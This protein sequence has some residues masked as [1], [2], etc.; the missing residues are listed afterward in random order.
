MDPAGPDDGALGHAAEP[1]ATPKARFKVPAERLDALKDQIADINRKVARLQK[2]GYSE[3]EPVAI[4]VGEL[5]VEQVKAPT[6]ATL[7]GFRVVD[8]VFADVVLVSPKPPKID[9]WEFVAALSHV[10]DV[11]AVLRVCPGADVAEGELKRFREA[12]ACCDHC[13]TDRKRNET[14]VVRNPAAELKQVGRQ[15]LQAYTGLKNPEVLCQRAELLFAAAAALGSAE[16]EWAPEGRSRS[17]SSVRAYLPFVACS[18]RETGWLSRTEARARADGAVSTAD[19][20]LSRGLFAKPATIDPLKPQECD[21]SRASATIAFCDEYF[22]GREVDALSDYENSLRV[23]MASGVLHPKLVGIVASAV[24]FYDRDLERRARADSWAKVVA[25]STWQGAVGERQVFEDLK[26]V[27]HRSWEGDFG[28]TNL[29]TLVSEEGHCFTYFASRDM[30]LSVGQSVSLKATV[31]K[32]DTYAPKNG[33]TPHK[34]TVL[35][36]CAL[37]ARARVVGVDTVEV[38]GD[39]VVSNPEAVARGEWAEYTQ[40]TSTGNAYHLEASDGRRFVFH[41]KAKKKALTVGSEHVVEYHSDYGT[42]Q[43]GERPVSLVPDPRRAIAKTLEEKAP[44][45]EAGGLG[46]RHASAPRRTQGDGQGERSP[47]QDPF[48]R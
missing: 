25:N 31:K 35:T 23:A 24:P 2:R 41:S 1:A 19:D 22:A 4:D 44:T 15:C 46:V 38:P 16:G 27:G 17:F 47:E 34:Q 30:H 18:I 3:V 12:N 5:Y 37:V 9:G 28:V 40:R 48:G 45:R 14:F 7:E 11:G 42:D 43:R 26:V 33:G 32:H 29:Y 21:Y 13:Q 20:A 6:P 36:R 39:M 8:R 10:Q